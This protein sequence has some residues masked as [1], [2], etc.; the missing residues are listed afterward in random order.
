MDVFKLPPHH[1]PIPPPGPPPLTQSH[2]HT[3]AQSTG[4]QIYVTFKDGSQNGRPAREM[5]A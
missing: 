5:R 1:L 3:H 4:K 2:T